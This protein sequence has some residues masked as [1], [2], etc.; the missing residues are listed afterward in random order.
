MTQTTLIIVR[1]GNTFGPGDVI[2]RLGGKT[3]LPLVESGLEQGRQIGTYLKQENLLPDVVYTSHLKRTIQTAQQALLQ[4]GLN[5]DTYP[6]DSFN[7]IDYGIDENIAEDDVVNRLGQVAVS[8]LMESGDKPSD[9]DP[10]A[11]E[12]YAL[13]KQSIKLWDTDCIVP[14]GWMADADAMKQDWISFS[15]KILQD[16]HGETIM[17]VSSNGVLRFAPHILADQESF[18]RE[19]NLKFATGAVG[20]FVHDGHGWSCTSWNVKPKDVL[21]T[22]PSISQK[23]ANLAP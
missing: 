5:L 16:H 6:V 1:H 23:G 19:H 15:E 11:E 20:V 17:V 12:I 8:Q 22:S 7:E 18:N 9:W 13:G 14:N 2:T 3:D 21:Q 10:S 4:M